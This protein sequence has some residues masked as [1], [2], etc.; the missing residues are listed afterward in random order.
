MSPPLV[1]VNA[2]KNRRRSRTFNLSYL[3]RMETNKADRFYRK[4]VARPS[5][6]PPLDELLEELPSVQP[7]TSSR[8]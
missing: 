4:K 8:S 3:T 2:Q 6:A 7:G 5:Q 1:C